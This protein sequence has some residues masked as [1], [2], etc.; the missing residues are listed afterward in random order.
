MNMSMGRMQRV[1]SGR[2]KVTQTQ[3]EQEL[4]RVWHFRDMKETNQSLRGALRVG[5]GGGGSKVPPAKN[6]QA[7]LRRA[8]YTVRVV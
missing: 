2:K 8:P 1:R 3:R 5:G 6:Q 7:S 4:F